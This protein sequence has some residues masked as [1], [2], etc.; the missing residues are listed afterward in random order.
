VVFPNNS[1]KKS[2][3]AGAAVVPAKVAS[4]TTVVGDAVVVGASVVGAAVVVDGAIVVVD[5]VVG[6]IEITKFKTPVNLPM[7]SSMM[8][9]S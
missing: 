4:F 8:T 3:A 2:A 5:V 1:F 9:M 7:V 6:I